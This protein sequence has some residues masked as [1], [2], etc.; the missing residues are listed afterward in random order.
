MYSHCFLKAAFLFCIGL[1]FCATVQAEYRYQTPCPWV[2]AKDYSRDPQPFKDYYTKLG[3]TTNPKEVGLSS[4]NCGRAWRKTRRSSRQAAATKSMNRR[5][6]N[7]TV[8][9]SF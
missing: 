6:R 2:L 8:T 1:S 4:R 5:R 9:I 7:S 3:I